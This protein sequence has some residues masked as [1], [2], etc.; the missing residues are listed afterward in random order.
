[1]ALVLDPYT[2][3]FPQSKWNI[4]IPVENTQARVILVL[5]KVVCIHVSFLLYTFKLYL[6]TVFGK[7]K[8]YKNINYCIVLLFNIFSVD[9][10]F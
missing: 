4:I 10:V 9:F 6:E 7:K 5:L 2:L 8:L 3:K 1:M